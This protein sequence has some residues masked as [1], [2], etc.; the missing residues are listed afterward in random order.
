MTTTI[1]YLVT[2]TSNECDD[3]TATSLG[4][5]GWSHRTTSIV[6]LYAS[7]PLEFA[8]VAAAPAFPQ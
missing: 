4:L 2:V 5:V 6:G 7:V 1:F 8:P 3:C